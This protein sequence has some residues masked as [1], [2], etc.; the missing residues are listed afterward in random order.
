[1]PNVG[2]NR[3]SDR[4]VTGGVGRHRLMNAR[5]EEARTH[6][7]PMGNSAVR[8]GYNCAGIDTPIAISLAS[9]NGLREEYG[10]P[11]HIELLRPLVED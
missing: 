1:M 11:T 2:S 5:E 3:A 7:F 9:F 6:E 10:I 8:G 4:E